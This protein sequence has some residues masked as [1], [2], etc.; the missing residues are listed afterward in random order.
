MWPNSVLGR[1]EDKGNIMPCGHHL[2]GA[3]PQRVQ[4]RTEER[5][6]EKAGV[7]LHAACIWGKGGGWAGPAL[8]QS[9]Y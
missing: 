1:K 3:E 2:M 8:L 5:M 9:A 7:F 6:C 4:R